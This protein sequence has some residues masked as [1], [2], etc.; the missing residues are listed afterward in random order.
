MKTPIAI[1]LLLL[2][3]CKHATTTPE[4][5]VE[6]PVD[7]ALETDYG[8]A[9]ALSPDASTLAFTGDQ[10]YVRR[11]NERKSTPLAGTDGARSPFFSPDGAW[12][13]FFTTTQLKKIPAAGGTAIAVCD[14]SSG[15]GGTWSPDGNIIFATI[16]G[17]LWQVPS[18]G[19]KP[20][21]LTKL[22]LN[23]RETT[24]R[25]PQSLSNG[26]FVLFTAHSA[27]E[28]LED[29]HVVIQDL[30]S[31]KRRV[32]HRGG[33]HYRY[34]PSGSLVYLSQGTL[35]QVP[36]DLARFDNERYE[37]KRIASPVAESVL[38]YPHN[39]AAQIAVSANG[40]LV[41][42]QTDSR[43]EQS[44]NWVGKSKFLRAAPDHYY[45]LALSP[46]GPRAAFGL[47]NGSQSNIAVYDWEKDT[48]THITGTTGASAPIWTP[49]GK[50]ETFTNGN[51]IF[52]QRA[53][54]SGPAQL[55][56][57]A[58]PGSVRIPEA[59]HPSGKYL[60]FR[61]YTSEGANDILTI[62]MKGEEAGEVKTI[63]SG[64]N[65]ELDA[66]FSPDGKWITFV[67]NALLNGVGGVYRVYARPFP[68]VAIP[69]LVTP[70]G[71]GTNPTW[72]KDGKRIFY[73]ATDG[74]IMSV[75]C[76]IVGQTIGYDDPIPVSEQV[77]V[78]LAN[79]RSYD[80]AGDGRLALLE[81]IPRSNPNKAVVVYNFS[82]SPDR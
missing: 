31:G 61:E 32:V 21:A 81:N 80:Q 25:W 1:T 49:D 5:R 6:V 53:D 7:V 54:G 14:E 64:P 73:R 55:L 36:F 72:S 18:A 44:I 27:T 3:S 15:R 2:A 74:R 16:H 35:Q 77:A 26:R 76:R 8:P 59:W 60:A 48:T 29:A 20:A 11:L 39:G 67:S 68:G 40:T 51:N 52:W 42:V 70:K 24:Q 10:L 63:V 47:S 9:I 79:V 13:A 4:T 78:D 34:L 82:S 22:D 17:G 58:K 41:F 19:G 30:R 65:D 56:T 37:S 33:Y 28:W 12:I 71:G 75:T 45:G 38:A 46:N 66:A 69:F 23:E 43:G 62:E 57:S 50:R